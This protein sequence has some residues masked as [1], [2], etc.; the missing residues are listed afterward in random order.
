MNIG[1]IKSNV[2]CPNAPIHDANGLIDPNAKSGL[3]LFALPANVSIMNDIATRIPPTTTNGNMCDTP[4]R[5]AS[6]HLLPKLLKSIVA[7]VENICGPP[8]VF[9]DDSITSV[10][11]PASKLSTVALAS[12]IVFEIASL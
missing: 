10:L 3:V 2:T 8:V 1:T 9:T 5:T 6:Q 11:E 4:L 12:L 7:S